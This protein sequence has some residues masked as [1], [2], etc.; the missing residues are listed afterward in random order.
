MLEHLFE[1]PNS[2]PKLK[3]EEAK[4]SKADKANI[5]QVRYGNEIKSLNYI[6]LIL[7]QI[8]ETY[9]AYMNNIYSK[10]FII[11]HIF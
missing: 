9:V 3:E 10:Y 6:Q 7:K 11:I 1:N 5:E 4:S 2:Y 8:L